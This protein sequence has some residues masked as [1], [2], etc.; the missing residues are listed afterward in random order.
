MEVSTTG[1]PLPG[2][3]GTTINLDM[4]EIVPPP[5]CEGKKSTRKLESGHFDLDVPVF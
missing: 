2:D 5:R 1:G 3:G 4:V